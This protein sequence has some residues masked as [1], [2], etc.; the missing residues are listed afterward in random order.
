MIFADSGE[1]SAA[2]TCS[3]GAHTAQGKLERLI[4]FSKTDF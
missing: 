1:A 2:C 4:Y 3:A